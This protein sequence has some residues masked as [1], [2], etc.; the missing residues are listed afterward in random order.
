MSLPNLGTS[1][2][3]RPAPSSS[4]CRARPHTA[5]ASW[6]IRFT[7][8]TGVAEWNIEATVRAEDINGLLRAIIYAV[9]R[10]RC[11]PSSRSRLV[12]PIP[13][14][15]PDVLALLLDA[16]SKV[17]S[18]PEARNIA[19][20]KE[21]NDQRRHDASEASS[22]SRHAASLAMGKDQLETL[23]RTLAI[24][25][26]QLEMGKEGLRLQQQIEARQ[27]E[28]FSIQTKQAWALFRQTPEGLY[29]RAWEKAAFELLGVVSAR[30]KALQAILRTESARL[31]Q[32]IET[33]ELPPEPPTTPALV[34]IEASAEPTPPDPDSYRKMTPRAVRASNRS[35][36]ILGVGFL[37]LIV[38]LLA[39]LTSGVAVIYSLISGQP[40][41]QWAT[42]LPWWGWIV[43]ILATFV[44]FIV[45]SAVY[46]QVN[47]E[48]EREPNHEA[49]QQALAK[50]EEEYAAWQRSE[51][52]RLEANRLHESTLREVEQSRATFQQ[53]KRNHDLVI[54]ARRNQLAQLF[55][56]D[57][58]LDPK[59]G[60]AAIDEIIF[61]AARG[62]IEHPEPDEL[63]VL[64]L[65][66]MKN[67]ADGP[68]KIVG[69]WLR[70][71]QANPRTPA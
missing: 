41:P 8:P 54:A 22:D 16:A 60:R 68:T 45:G 63:P 56:F 19:E 36:M 40:T 44:G 7:D 20:A 6:Q 62:R 2:R 3:I 69:D 27:N 24:Q 23:S 57:W 71:A 5:G 43:T 49:H 30:D 52:A 66:S 1:T 15:T 67:A 14:V 31:S 35:M 4:A 17:L 9:E 42:V 47:G 13:P 50:H 26:E 33:T 11:L 55:D 39:A 53:A 64:A 65:P 21:R 59:H 70:F 29:Y 46:G 28:Q 12:I 38:L 37:L 51:V 61:T 18:G 10:Q 58:M 34:V 25:A 32:Q 48:H